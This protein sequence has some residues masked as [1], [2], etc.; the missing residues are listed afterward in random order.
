MTCFALQRYDWFDSE[1][2]TAV[3]RMASLIHERPGSWF[4]DQ[5]SLINDHL[6]RMA[7]CGRPQVSFASNLRVQKPKTPE[8]KTPGFRTPDQSLMLN[9][10]FEK[11]EAHSPVWPRIVLET[12]CSQTLRSVMNKAWDYLLDFDGE[13]HAVV[14]CNMNCPI[15]LKRDFKVS[16]GVW[17]RKPTY[18]D[19]KPFDV[20]LVLADIL[21]ADEDF[22]KEV[23]PNAHE[24][25]P[26]PAQ[27]VIGEEEENIAALTDLSTSISDGGTSATVV[28]EGDTK[29]ADLENDRTYTIP[30]K[31]GEIWRRSE[32]PIVS[33][34]VERYTMFD[35]HLTP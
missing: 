9:T 23:F 30:G 12:A 24:S 2:P 3:L 21:L 19:G 32:K 34:L 20:A 22:P 15:T 27:G 35:S 28:S 5:K 7:L 14:V 29:V 4:A 11:D 26:S 33:F 25:R 16:I 10:Y 31:D 18:K 1:V 17:I 13:V 6:S 8:I